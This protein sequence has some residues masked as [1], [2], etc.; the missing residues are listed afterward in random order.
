MAGVVALELTKSRGPV[1]KAT[2]AP[3]QL[4]Q[5]AVREEGAHVPQAFRRTLCCAGVLHCLTCGLLS[6]AYVKE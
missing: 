2:A 5:L 4:P 6:A 1:A 3:H